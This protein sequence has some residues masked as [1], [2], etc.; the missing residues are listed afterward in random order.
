M[1]KKKKKKA[2]TFIQ[3]S[4]LNQMNI[5]EKDSLQPFVG[6]SEKNNKNIINRNINTLS[7]INIPIEINDKGIKNEKTNNKV[8]STSL[9]NYSD[10]LKS[11]SYIKSFETNN[12]KIQ[13]TKKDSLLNI[14]KI[15]NT[16]NKKLEKDKN[17][18][19]QN[20]DLESIPVKVN[21][22][23][24]SLSTSLPKEN[25][26]ENDIKNLENKLSPSASLKI[27]L[28]SST[29][30]SNST[31]T[32]LNHSSIVIPNTPPQSMLKE[33]NYINSTNLIKP[34]D[35]SLDITSV[36]TTTELYKAN[37]ITIPVD[38]KSENISSHPIY[39]SISIPISQQSNM[40]P[41]FIME[42]SSSITQQPQTG[43]LSGANF[44]NNK[45]YINIINDK[46][47]IPVNKNKKKGI[48]SKLKKSIIGSGNKSMNK[49]INKE[50]M[51]KHIHSKFNSIEI[52]LNE[53]ISSTTSQYLKTKLSISNK[54]PSILRESLTNPILTQIKPE[55]LKNT[56]IPIHTL[57][58]IEL[59]NQD[60]VTIPSTYQKSNDEHSNYY[61]HSVSSSSLNVNNLSSNQKLEISKF[62][63]NPLNLPMS[64]LDSLPTTSDSAMKITPSLDFDS[65]YNTISS[66][67]NSSNINNLSSINNSTYNMIN[68]Y[69]DQS[70]VNSLVH[71]NSS[72]IEDLSSNMK[73][74]INKKD[75]NH[76]DLKKEKEEKEKE[77]EEKEKEKEKDQ[78]ELNSLALP[79]ATYVECNSSNQN[80]KKMTFPCGFHT[81][82]IDNC[83]CNDCPVAK[84]N[85]SNLLNN[86]TDIDNMNT[87]SSLTSLNN[88]L[89][90]NEGIINSKDI[91]MLTNDNQSNTNTRL[92]NEMSVNKNKNNDNNNIKNQEIEIPNKYNQNKGI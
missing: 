63:E 67:F 91:Q 29:S 9:Y 16:I 10:N 49:K 18:F 4:L 51:N 8:T 85:L 60:G 59:M 42:S 15:N 5:Y 34:L 84:M 23:S 19:Y 43:I 1:I 17:I 26:T 37:S 40:Y 53:P 22:I 44:S 70:D 46:I 72:Y 50:K 7:S 38:F 75:E 52:P 65:N 48:E 36:P 2:N 28:S 35:K 68:Y 32:K 82:C 69:K 57:N 64:N 81:P 71:L 56:L 14:E 58:N 12:T 6:H 30:K 47:S 76:L 92:S 80:M 13:D 20:T 11:H 41:S 54:V 25:H 61:F 79:S 89:S 87:D 83:N 21:Q 55:S 31:L 74:E 77:K 33:H 39:S 45:N 24:S 66:S 86:Y 78:T 90:T 88:V 3:K 62:R 73:N 27:S